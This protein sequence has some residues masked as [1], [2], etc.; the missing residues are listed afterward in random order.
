MVP[1]S[2]LPR[3]WRGIL[4]RAQDVDGCVKPS[5]G[6]PQF[7]SRKAGQLDHVV[8]MQ[9]RD[10]AG[11]EILAAQARFVGGACCAQPEV[12]HVEGVLHTQGAGNAVFGAADGRAGGGAEGDE[13][14]RVSPR[15]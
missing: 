4:A 6:A 15:L 11:P 7:H 2:C 3:G 8:R 1:D 10:E 13:F 5:T 12:D 14:K 9:V